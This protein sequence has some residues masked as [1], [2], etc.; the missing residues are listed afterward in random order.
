MRRCLIPSEYFLIGRGLVGS[1]PTLSNVVLM[2][3][4]EIRLLSEPKNRR[5]S[6]PVNS[7]HIHEFS[8][9]TP[10]LSEQ[11]PLWISVLFKQTFPVVGFTSPLKIRKSI[12]FPEPFSPTKPHTFP[13][14][15]FKDIFCNICLEPIF[16]ETLSAYKSCFTF[17]PP[18]NVRKYL[19]G[20]YIM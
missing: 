7:G 1:S 4:F 12:V 2:S 9:I 16:L 10:I 18:T 3:A 13:P 8:I 11:R 19:C 17:A 14:D 5:F 20:I 15:K 6:H